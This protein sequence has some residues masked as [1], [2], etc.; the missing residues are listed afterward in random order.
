MRVLHS[1]ARDGLGIS[2][3]ALLNVSVSYEEARK[4]ALDQVPI[5]RILQPEEIGQTCVYLASEAASG[6]TAQAM[7]VCGGQVMNG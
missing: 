2:L 5:G 1:L 4:F 7:N 6:L 3:P